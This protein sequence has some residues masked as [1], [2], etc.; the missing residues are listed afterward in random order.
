LHAAARIVA[1][2]E[3]NIPFFIRSDEVRA[4][5]GRPHK[6]P[7]NMGIDADPGRENIFFVS[8][9]VFFSIC[10]A[11]DFLH[12]KEDSTEN[13]NKE[14]TITAAQNPKDSF[15]TAAAYS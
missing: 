4:P 1:S 3:D 5:K 15:K 14:G 8:F 6:K 12:K 9:E 2:R 11:I 10:S 13:G 7:R